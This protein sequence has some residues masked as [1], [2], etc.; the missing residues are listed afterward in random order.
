MN[1]YAACFIH[2]RMLDALKVLCVTDVRFP[3]DVKMSGGGVDG[4]ETPKQAM[5]REIW[6]ET[7]GTEVVQSRLIYRHKF[8]NHTKNFFLATEIATPLDINQ[9]FRHKEMDPR[10]GRWVEHLIAQW[11]PIE[12]FADHLY[13]EQHD[14]FGAILG[15]L[16]RHEGFFRRY[17][18]LLERFPVPENLGLSDPE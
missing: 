17:G 9:I 16:I 4:R 10:T 14:A 5:A 11:V 18:H 15:E 2:N 1:Q 3:L 6:T 7:G 8:L 12:V 13:H